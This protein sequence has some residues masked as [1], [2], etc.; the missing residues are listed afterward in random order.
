MPSLVQGRI[1]YSKVPIPDPQGRNPK[2]GRPFVIITRSGEIAASDTVQAVGI[3]DELGESPKDHY[4]LLPWG[5]NARTGLKTKSAALCTWLVSISRD[6]LEVGR[7][8]I[9]AELVLAIVE[10]VKQLHK[11]AEAPDDGKN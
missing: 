6:K 10:K 9:N 8:H 2:P 4:I 3:T 5:E 1:V 11:P 7:G